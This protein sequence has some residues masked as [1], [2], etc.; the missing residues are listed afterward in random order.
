MQWE[1][2]VRSYYMLF[3][4]EATNEFLGSFRP[5]IHFS[6]GIVVSS[7]SLRHRDFWIQRMSRLEWEIICELLEYQSQFKQLLKGMRAVVAIW[8]GQ[9]TPT[10]REKEEELEIG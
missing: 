6:S 5:A 3:Q 4:E 9:G 2:M 7:S 8:D 10:E 1:L